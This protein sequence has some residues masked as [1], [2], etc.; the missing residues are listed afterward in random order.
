MSESQTQKNEKNPKSK[1]VFKIVAIILAFAITFTC[2]YF[3]KYI[4]DSNKA[5]STTDLINL[6]D[7]VGYIID[8]NGNERTL[9]K[10]DYLKAIANGVLDKYSTFYTK[11]EYEEI[12]KKRSGDYSGFGLGADNSEN[13]EAVVIKVVGNS[14]ADREGIRTGDKIKSATFNGQTTNFSNSKELSTFLFARTKGDVVEF[15]VERNGKEMT[16]VVEKAQFTASYVAYFDSQ[17]RISFHT[18]NGTMQKVEIENE[19]I[20]DLGDNTA[21]IRLDSFEGDVGKQLARAIECAWWCWI[22]ITFASY[23]SANS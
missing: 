7:R 14:P 21:L 9:T 17:K 4:F 8:E 3:S 2:G 13:K 11:E 15:N 1:K 10:E 5:T 12:T 22:G 18:V 16:F 20:E 23:F 19:K 6:I